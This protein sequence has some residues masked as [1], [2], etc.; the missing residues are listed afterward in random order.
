MWQ[1]CV[2]IEGY[3]VVV[4]FWGLL[5]EIR[6]PLRMRRRVPHG[7]STPFNLT[8][9]LLSK[10]LLG[11]SELTAYEQDGLHQSTHQLV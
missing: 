5:C 1:S 8:T 7:Y 3:Y 6:D 11:Y 2:E 4:K 9:Q 10:G